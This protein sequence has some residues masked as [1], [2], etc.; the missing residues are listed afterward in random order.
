MGHNISGFIADKD[1][2]KMATA[3][4]S[5]AHVIAL[6]CHNLG[7][8]PYTWDLSDEIKKSFFHRFDFVVAFI[9]TDYFGGAGEQRARVKKGRE[10]ILRRGE[11]NEALRL[12]GVTGDA[13]KDEFDKVGLGQW[14]NNEDWVEFGPNA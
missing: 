8:L 4:L 3:E 2:L 14:R 6:K 5:S 7:F 1:K 11:I 12:L 9:E 10:I 13:N